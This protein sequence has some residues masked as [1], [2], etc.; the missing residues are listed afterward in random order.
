MPGDL[1]KCKTCALGYKPTGNENDPEHPTGCKPD[2]EL[3]KFLIIALLIIFC[4][5]LPIC[6]CLIGTVLGSYFLFFRDKKQADNKRGKD[7]KGPQ[8][9]SSDNDFQEKKASF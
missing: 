4:C 6:I 2:S 8:I 7:S 1:N 9:A 5:I 3:E